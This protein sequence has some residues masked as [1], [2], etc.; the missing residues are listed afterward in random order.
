[1]S[2]NEAAFLLEKKKYDIKETLAVATIATT[3]GYA[4][5]KPSKIIL[6]MFD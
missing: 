4:S 3:N 5:C 6:K 1:M 2:F